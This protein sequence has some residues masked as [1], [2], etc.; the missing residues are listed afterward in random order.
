MLGYVLVPAILVALPGGSAGAAAPAIVLDVKG[1]IGPASAD[2]LHRGLETAAERGAVAV[3]LRLDTPGGLDTSM[4]EI[5]QDIL[6]SRVPV[7]CYVAPSGAR[8]ASAGTY[9]LYACHVA[10]MAPGTNL[11]AATPIQIGGAPTP[12]PREPAPDADGEKEKG[13]EA[14]PERPPAHPHP[15]LSDK[16]VNDAVAYIRSLA[17]LRGRN[18]DWAEKA[19]REAASLAAADAVREGVIDLL[20]ENMDDLLAKLD[21]RQVNVLGEERRLQTQGVAVLELEPDWRT[22][23]LATIT[24][25]NIAYILLLIGIYGL[26]FEFINPGAIAPGVIGGICLLLGLYALHLL[27]LDYAGL[28]LLLLGIALMT[29]EAFAPSFGVL[30]IGGA[31]A[32][33]IGSIILFDVGSEYYALSWPLVAA[34]ALASLAFSMIVLAMAAKARWRPVVSGPEEMIGVTGRVLEWRGREGRVRAHG[35]VWQAQ[36]AAPLKRGQQVR[37]AGIT[38]LTLKVEPASK[39][40]GK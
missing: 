15:T 24:N 25:P 2:Y 1:P 18:A 21:G 5:I 30:G 4:R 23:L 6:S 19:V 33:V 38:G 29:A 13:G 17:Q 12:T 16:V 10:A 32:F 8:A 28:G 36:A 14:E 20:A 22:E 9:I 3:I 37:I 39:G 26:I 40:S 27:P 34:V 11:G 35:E 7:A 31:V